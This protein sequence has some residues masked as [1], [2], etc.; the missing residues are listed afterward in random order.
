MSSFINVN[1]LAT[2]VKIQSRNRLSVI[3]PLEHGKIVIK[4]CLHVFKCINDEKHVK[5]F[6]QGPKET[7]AWVRVA[8]R[9]A[10]G[11]DGI[12]NK[13]KRRLTVSLELLYLCNFRINYL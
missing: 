11:F 2:E 8:Q 1:A 7:L 5:C 12:T 6:H 10:D 4:G 3:L 9:Y 13:G